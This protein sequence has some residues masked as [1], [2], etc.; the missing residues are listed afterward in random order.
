M[1]M[2]IEGCN[3]KK[4]KHEKKRQKEIDDSKTNESIFL[5]EHKPKKS[6]DYSFFFSRSNLG[7][8]KT[9]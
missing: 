8:G 1:E 7:I 2:E 5:L 3:E 4:R 9:Y 6:I